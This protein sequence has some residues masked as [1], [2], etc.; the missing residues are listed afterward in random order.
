LRH[1]LTIKYRPEIDGIRAIAVIAVIIYHAELFIG[2]NILLKGGFIGVDIFFV[3]SGYLITSIILSSETTFSFSQ[4]Y[5]K[6]ARRIL[7]ALFLVMIFTI[8]FAWM[9]M[10]PKALEE[11][12]SSIISSLLFSSNFWFMQED[13]YIAEASEL[14]PFL[15]TWSLS[16]EEQFYVT[17]PFILIFINKYY[18]QYSTHALVLLFLSSLMLSQYGSLAFKDANFYLLPSRIWEL[19]AGGFL[20]KLELSKERT[21][22]QLANKIMPFI[23]ITLV[24]NSFIFLNDELNLPS[25]YTLIPIIGTMLIIWFGGSSDLTSKILSY[26]PL[27]AIGL[28]SYSLYLWHFPVFAFSRIT[29]FKLTTLDKIENIALVFILS[30]ATYFLIEKPARNQSFLPQK[31]FILITIAIFSFIF[32]YNTI[33]ISKNG[34]PNRLGTFKDIYE[35]AQRIWTKQKNK[36]CHKRSVENACHF[37]NNP[38]A[39]NYILL[40]DSHAGVLSSQ[41]LDY[42]ESINANFIQLTDGGCPYIHGVNRLTK[43]KVHEDCTTKTEEAYRFLKNTSPSTIIYSLRLPYYLSGKRFSNREGGRERGGD[44][45]LIL[46][47]KYRHTNLKPEEMIK[48]MIKDWLNFGHKVVLIYPIPEVGWRVPDLLKSKLNKI[49]ISERQDAFENISINTSY[50]LYRARTKSSKTTFDEIGQNQHLF[51]V[52]PDKILCRKETQRCYTHNDKKLFYYD[53][54][55]ISPFIAGKII[56][57]IDA[58]LNQKQH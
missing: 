49:R 10:L 25:F 47:E 29:N 32:I 50:R 28:I 37:I 26:R 5:E 57:E 7:P 31:K 48:T 2:Q 45:S 36:I 56:H 23:G 13:S 19:I 24:I 54:D 51:R 9:Y 40:G 3:I 30:I 8:P 33:L 44:T 15:H 39:M 52:Y 46:T 41:L 43:N 18:K 6:R 12:A 38:T 35:D 55:H 22:H 20:A 1:P 21:K 17:F 34:F 4:F 42:T 14:K 16:V 11:Y 53:D 27:V 58:S